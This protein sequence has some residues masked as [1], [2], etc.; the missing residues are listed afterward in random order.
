LRSQKDIDIMAPASGRRPHMYSSG[1]AGLPGLPLPDMTATMT[2]ASYDTMQ[3]SALLRACMHPLA[4]DI[5]SWQQLQYYCSITELLQYCSTV[6]RSQPPLLSR[7]LSTLR[8][9][10]GKKSRPA[11]WCFC[12]RCNSSALDYIFHKL[13]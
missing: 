8:V 9:S 7:A 2:N 6:M 12:Q 10:L 1:M 5:A 11:H 3:Q 4:V 13:P